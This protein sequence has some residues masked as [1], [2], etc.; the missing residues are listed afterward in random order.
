MSRLATVLT[1]LAFS[2]LT[3][4]CTSTR[5]TLGNSALGARVYPLDAAQVDGIL[6]Q[7]MEAEFGA[8]NVFKVA[9][10]AMAYEAELRDRVD[11]DTVTAVARPWKGMGEGGQVVD[12]Y[13]LEV[14]RSG[15]Y[16]SK[17]I[18][19]RDRVFERLIAAAEQVTPP[20]PQAPR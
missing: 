17:G 18:G 8:G 16:P 1:F 20:L 15:T 9:R 19:A 13:V 11:S 7:A 6:R 14:Q 5:S 10:D 4:A 3:L 2:L 12:G